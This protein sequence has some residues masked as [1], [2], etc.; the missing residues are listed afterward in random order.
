LIFQKKYLDDLEVLLRNTRAKLKKVLTVVSEDSQ[1]R[2]SLTLE[3]EAM[4]NK[5]LHEFS[6]PTITNIHTR[7]EVNAGDNGFKLKTTLITMVQA[8]QFCGKAYED[9]SAHLQHFLETCNTFTIKGVTRDAILLHL[10]LFSLLGK[11]MQWFYAN[12][13]KHTT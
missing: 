10:F 4:E 7:P 2:R 8:N 1:I 12:K 6:A 9:A 3:F 13:E 5:S 11:A